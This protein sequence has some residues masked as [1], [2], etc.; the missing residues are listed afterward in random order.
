MTARAPS[1]RAKLYIAAA[2]FQVAILHFLLA[3]M[4]KSAV[5]FSW[6]TPRFVFL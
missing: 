1:M 4:G 3:K 5:W 6:S 2:D